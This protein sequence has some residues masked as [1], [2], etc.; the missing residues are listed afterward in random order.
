M[1]ANPVIV[2]S[3]TKLPI[4]TNPATAAQ[5]LSG[6]EAIDGEGNKIVGTASGAPEWHT[7][8]LDGSQEVN[9]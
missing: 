8:V 7:L 5:I 4:L 9:D 6:Y 1:I 3:G 2:K